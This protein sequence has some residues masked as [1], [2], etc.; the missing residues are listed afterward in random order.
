VNSLSEPSG[1][2]NRTVL[3]LTHRGDAHLPFV[4]PHLEADVVVID[5]AAIADG[6][7]LGF[8]FSPSENRITHRGTVLRDVCGV[9]YRKPVPPA[10]EDLLG[11][12]DRDFAA[13]SSSAIVQHFQLL[14]RQFPDALW[15]SL[16]WRI[17]RASDKLAQLQ[18][19][20]E[21]GF[22]TPKTLFTSNVDE[23]TAFLREH[24]Q[25]VV[26]TISNEMPSG[27]SG[28]FIFHT[29]RVDSDIDLSHLNFAPAIFQQLIEPAFEVRATVVRGKVFPAR[30]DLIDSEST[31]F[32]DW[33]RGYFHGDLKV[34]ACTLPNA[35]AHACSEHVSQSGLQF[36]AIDLVVDAA[37]EHWFLENNPNGQW[38]WQ[39]EKTGQPIGKEL[40]AILSGRR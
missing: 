2:E 36:G 35:V 13:Y 31:P 15:V 20:S 9:W 8:W 21:I 38:A 17:R 1:K 11:I 32:R 16:P 24:K 26:K 7:A 33:R 4:V 10:P 5:P 23:A 34:D 22:K 6:E 14:W 18:L 12:V 39:E 3:I 29:T 40:A 30:I 28:N 27:P 25:S 37:G 19:A